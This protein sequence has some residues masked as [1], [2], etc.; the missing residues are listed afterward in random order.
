MASVA[1][2][3][4]AELSYVG[5]PYVWGGARP[6]GWDCSGMQNWVLNHDLGI[7]IPGYPPHTFNGAGHGPVVSDY[8]AWNGATTI[9]H[10]EAGCLC[11]FGPDG[12]MGVAI[13]ANRMV[14]ALDHIDG[15][16]ETPIKGYGPTGSILIYRRINDLSGTGSVSLDSSQQGQFQQLGIQAGC[17]PGVALIYRM[18][19]L[20]R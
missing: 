17:L 9:P 13:N 10:A 6:S 7:S 5:H 16:V 11:L 4:Q 8:I 18:M 20:C 15:T 2:L 1:E 14:S 12:H 19:M 3:T